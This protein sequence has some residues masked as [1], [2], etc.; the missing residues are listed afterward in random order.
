MRLVDTRKVGDGVVILTYV[1][2]QDPGRDG[3]SPAVVGA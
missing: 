1:R 3:G 2:V